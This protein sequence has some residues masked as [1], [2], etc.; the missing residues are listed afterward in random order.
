LIAGIAIVWSA[1]LSQGLFYADAPRTALLRIGPVAVWSEGV[2]HGLVQGLRGLAPTWAGMALAA[3]TDASRL[4]R[5]LIAL[6]FPRGPGFLVLA[7]IRFAPAMAR[8]ILEVRAARN[9]RIPAGWPRH[10]TELD[11]LRPLVARAVRRART[12]GDSLAARGVDL[13]APPRGV[14]L[15]PLSAFARAIVAAVAA[16]L[17]ALLVVEAATAL[18]LAD[19]VYMPAWR[20][21][22]GFAR[23]WL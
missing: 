5:G 4:H 7:G 20:P 17:V 13:A 23:S 8:E 3:S 2:R 21:L 14:P 22:Y 1:T 9:R 10:R 18:Y 12:L 19:L 15:R 6:G 11:L 16:A